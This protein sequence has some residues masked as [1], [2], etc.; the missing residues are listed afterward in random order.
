MLYVGMS[1]NHIFMCT[2][3]NS[4]ADV[5]RPKGVYRPL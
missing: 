4:C 3:S 2:A 1:I 5:Y